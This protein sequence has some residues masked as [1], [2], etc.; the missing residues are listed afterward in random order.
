MKIKK[1]LFFTLFILGLLF[2]IG[3]GNNTSKNN[4][5]NESTTTSSK[6]NTVN[7]N[8]FAKYKDKGVE[9]YSD[10]YYLNARGITL[11]NEYRLE[12]LNSM[13]GSNAPN[14]KM[15]PV[16]II[17][18]GDKSSTYQ[19]S[20]NEGSYYKY[21]GGIKS[22]MPSGY[23]DIFDRNMNGN[24]KQR[25]SGHFKNGSIDSYLIAYSDY[26]WD[27]T[28]KVLV[29][30]DLSQMDESSQILKEADVPS[31]NKLITASPRIIYTPS[32][33][34][35]VT[36][37]EYIELNGKMQ[38]VY[39]VKFNGDTV[40][41]EFYDTTGNL[42]AKLTYTKANFFDRQESL[43]P[44]TEYYSSGKIKYEGTGETWKFRDNPIEFKREGQGKQFD[45]DG[46]VIYDGMWE[47]NQRV[48][49]KQKKK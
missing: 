11:F 32:R 33:T 16:Q 4:H 12:Y 14:N 24:Y 42:L 22:D 23:G 40:Y 1:N 2:S 20:T 25:F 15:Y 10:W 28:L 18:D 17:G 45:E 27:N 3:C 6:T 13:I 38:I 21:R 44:L 47:S 26:Y 36:K 30:A 19:V 49:N 41:E 9:L 7:E 37:E 35:V 48:S 39:K 34:Y 46:N 5:T 29:E 8:L 31:T 43:V